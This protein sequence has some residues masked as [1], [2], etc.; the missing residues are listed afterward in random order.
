M[1][2]HQKLSELYRV[3]PQAVREQVIRECERLSKE[4]RE[5]TLAPGDPTSFLGGKAGFTDEER[6]ETAIARQA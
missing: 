5:A 1:R 3:A 2:N 4:I 6:L